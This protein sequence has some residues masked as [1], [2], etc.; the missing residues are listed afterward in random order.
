MAWID[1]TGFYGKMNGLWR[2]NG[3]SDDE[4]DF[5]LKDGERPVNFFI[6]GE[7]GDGQWAGGYRGSEH[8]EFPSRIP[9]VDDDPACADRDWCNQYGL[10][11][12]APITDSDIPWW[13]AC[14]SESP[15][16]TEL[17]LPVV[18]EIIDGGIKLVYEGRLTKQADGDGWWDGD[19]CHQDWLFPDGIRRPVFLR[20]GYELFGERDYFDRTMQIYNP[21]GNPQFNGP[22]SLI[23][24]FVITHWPDPHP[25]KRIHS[26]MRPEL[27][28]VEDTLHGVTL[29]AGQWNSHD[30]WHFFR[31]EVFGWLNQPFSLSTTNDYL[32][33]RS[34]TVSHVG[35]SDNEDVGICLCYVHGAIEMGGGL[36]HGGISLPI[37]GGQSTIEAVRRLR[38]PGSDVVER[39]HVYEA[40]TDLM[41]AIGRQE[42]DG[43]SANTVDDEEGHM[44]YGP[45]ATDWG[46]GSAEASFYL[47]VDNNSADNY[48]VVTLD[49][50]DASE[51]EILVLRPVQRGEFQNIYTYQSFTL[52]ADLSGRTGHMME[53]RVY[54]HDISYV[55]LDK[56]VVTTIQ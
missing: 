52:T 34:A 56:V 38:L 14:N 29:Y 37:D 55:R 31:D 13:S 9:E 53:V 36:I 7:F 16:W 20:V 33:G 43:W 28:D 44:A 12:A 8:I 24:G 15:D 45:Y 51:D 23:G 54:W 46:G 1:Q 17:F 2:L 48:A 50:Y 39:V 10:S 30:Y 19:F 35:P 4:L 21:E 26:F 47:M 11:E 49:I 18:E 25:L 3:L 6:V 32:T 42:A 41:H 27:Y 22:M 40:E 5:V